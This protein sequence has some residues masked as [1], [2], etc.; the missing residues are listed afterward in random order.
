MGS[1]AVDH[2][3]SASMGSSS[4]SSLHAVQCVSMRAIASVQMVEMYRDW[5]TVRRY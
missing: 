5:L 3:A 4:G 1:G 2:E